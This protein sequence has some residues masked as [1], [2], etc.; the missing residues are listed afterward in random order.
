MGDDTFIDRL[1]TEIE[2]GV[3]TV[4]GVGTRDILIQDANDEYRRRRRVIRSGLR[5]LG[6]DDPNPWTDLWLWYGFYKERQE[7]ASYQARREHII[8]RYQP[9]LDALERLGLLWCD[10]LES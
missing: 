6:L 9:L 4:S 8:R 2:G 3:A 10:G 5:T 7:L 1:S